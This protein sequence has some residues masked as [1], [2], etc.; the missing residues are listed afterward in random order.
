MAGGREIAILK[1]VGSG[2]HQG[3]PRNKIIQ[4]YHDSSH[5]RT[6]NLY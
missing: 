3:S 2:G 6:W 4:F 5:V 1:T